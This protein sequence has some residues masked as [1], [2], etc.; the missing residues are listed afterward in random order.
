MPR[1]IKSKTRYKLAL[2]RKANRARK[3][4]L[5]RATEDNREGARASKRSR[6]KEARDRD[7]D[8]DYNNDLA[9]FED[10]TDDSIIANNKANNKD[11]TRATVY[12]L[13]Y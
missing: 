2:I 11:L 1:Y 5:T 8:K 3:R 7:R 9:I 4:A 12:T 10:S 13:S 6:V